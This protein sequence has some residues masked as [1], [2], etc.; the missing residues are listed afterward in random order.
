M[1]LLHEQFLYCKK[2]E[3][4]LP[5]RVN[6]DCLE[7]FFGTVRATQ[8]KPSA[9][10]FKN[11]IK[12][13]SVNQY[14]KHLTT[15]SYDQDNST[16][17]VD[18]LE[19]I[20]QIPKPEP[21]L[22]SFPECP[23]WVLNQKGNPNMVK[24]ELMSLYNTAGY[25]ISTIIKNKYKKCDDC[26]KQ[27]GSYEPIQNEF[28]RLQNLKQF[29]GFGNQQSGLFYVND[30]TF[31]LF[32]QLENVFRYFADLNLLFKHNIKEHLEIQMSRIPNMFPSCHSIQKRM[33]T[34]F[35]T[36]RLKIYSKRKTRNGITNYASNSMNEQ[37]FV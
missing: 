31:T 36:F 15:G 10:E 18:F 34:N 23:M 26:I 32:R 9:L 13:L 35:V 16:L 6:Q 7:N 1:M 25:L 12:T 11:I 22:E 4:F 24:Y 17:M 29:K 37:S 3:F 19:T 20:D 8:S 33:I 30:K 28:S 27:L 14:M 5:G 21:V 2:W